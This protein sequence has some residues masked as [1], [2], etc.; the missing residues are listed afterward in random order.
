MML[1]PKSNYTHNG[2]LINRIVDFFSE[3]V[4]VILCLQ[5]QKY[6]VKHLPDPVSEKHLLL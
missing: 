5:A 6:R 3:Q 1:P 4:P 2:K